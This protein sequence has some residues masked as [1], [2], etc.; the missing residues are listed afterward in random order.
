MNYSAGQ[1]QIPQRNL[2]SKSAGHSPST[3]S[4]VIRHLLNILESYLTFFQL[5]LEINAI[6]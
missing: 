1:S 6:Q 3:G 4:G 5:I 2:I